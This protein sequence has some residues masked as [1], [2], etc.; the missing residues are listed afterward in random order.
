[1]D[2]L[3]T[4][5]LVEIE[6]LNKLVSKKFFLIEC[7]LATG[8]LQTENDPDTILKHGVTNYY[9]SSVILELLIKILYE[10]EFRKQA[11]FKHNILKIYE[12]LSTDIKSFV[13]AKYDE[14]R[15]RKEKIFKEIDSTVSFPPFHQLLESNE[16]F[17]KNFKYDAMGSKTNS[18]VDGVFYVEMFNFINAEKE[19]LNDA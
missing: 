3:P 10:L 12:Q 2:K 14:A 8:K 9:L 19:K 4:E 6:E 5:R 7:F 1:M 16:D 13:R 15:K 17:I 11:P 18:A